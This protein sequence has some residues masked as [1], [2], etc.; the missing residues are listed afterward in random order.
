M[1]D[2]LRHITEKLQP[3]YTEAV[4]HQMTASEAGQQFIYVIVEDIEDKLLYERFFANNDVHVMISQNKDGKRGYQNVEDIV[5]HIK[6]DGITQR[7]CGIRDADYTRYEDSN[8]TFPDAIFVTDYRDLEMLLL[9]SASV[10]QGLQQNNPQIDSNF[11]SGVYT[12]ARELGY[13]RICNHVCNLGCNFK[14]NVR[15]SKVWDDKQHQLVADWKE[16]LKQKFIENCSN[17]QTPHYPYTIDELN[18]FIADKQLT[19]ET[20]Y[21]ICQGHDVIW[22]LYKRLNTNIKQKEIED[23]IYTS[24]S[25]TDFHSTQLYKD[26]KSWAIENNIIL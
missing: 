10:E 13:L 19:D 8:H 26:I 6:N 2:S 9:S 7:I 12:D 22:L 4:I 14:R 24:Y 1:A 15:L 11:L 16:Q 17:T 5:T 3:L 21:N 20:A 25:E 18:K 23:C